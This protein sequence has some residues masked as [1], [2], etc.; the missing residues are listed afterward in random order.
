[1]CQGL[2][3]LDWGDPDVLALGVLAGL[4]E[5]EVYDG[6]VEAFARGCYVLESL[7]GS[8]RSSS[9]VR[10]TS[11]GERLGPWLGGLLAGGWCRGWWSS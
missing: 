10:V 11:P 5:D 7:D 2:A 9:L 6:L 8:A 4:P 1:M 3:P